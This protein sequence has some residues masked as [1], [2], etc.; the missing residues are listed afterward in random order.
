M[1]HYTAGA[2]GGERPGSAVYDSDRPRLAERILGALREAEGRQA[3][4][5][6]LAARFGIGVDAVSRT[7]AE[8]RGLG[9]DVRAEGRGGGRRYRIAHGAAPLALPWEVVGGRGGGGGLA[10]TRLGSRIVFYRS[11]SSTQELA[12]AAAGSGGSDGL[13]VIAGTQ[14]AG[15]GRTGKRW[16]SPGGGLWMSAV[17]EPGPPVRAATLVPLAAALAVSDAVEGAVGVQADLKWPNDL[18]VGGRKVAGILVDAAAGARSLDA[19]VVG[20]GV[21]LAVDAKAVNSEA[22]LPRGHGGAASLLPPAGTGQAPASA[23]PALL[24]RSIIER[25]ERELEGLEGGAGSVPG[26]WAERSSMI[27]R[28]VRADYS[29]RVVEGT[30]AGIDSD[31]SL[32][33]REGKRT[34]KV[35]AGNV[36]VLA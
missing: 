23:D 17:A 34:A 35:I 7:V 6:R 20:V 36:A 28:R 2:D 22:H 15:R 14:T 11:A 27:G 3:G 19:V 4:A 16:I 26:R 21:N 29:G 9:Y 10:A 31:G 25:L 8:L 1:P 18:L 33:V 5:A 12:L 24:A 13:V 30:A 32:L